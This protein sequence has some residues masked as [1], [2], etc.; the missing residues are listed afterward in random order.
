MSDI[1][2]CIFLNLILHMQLSRYPS[3]GVQ[4]QREGIL[5]RGDYLLVLELRIQCVHHLTVLFPTD[6]I[7]SGLCEL[8]INPTG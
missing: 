5:Q 4:V 3:N 2:L 1:F 8:L 6:A 7:L